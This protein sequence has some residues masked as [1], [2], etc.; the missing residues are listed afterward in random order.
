MPTLYV[1]APPDAAETLARRVVEERLAAC[2]NRVPC[3]SVYRWEGTIHED[4]EVILFVKTRA[5]RT[6]ELVERIQE[7]HPHDVPCVERFEEDDVLT[8]FEEWRTAATSEQ[9]G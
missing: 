2:V 7:I 5:G 8:A 1:T 6:D 4:E 3:T 9:Q